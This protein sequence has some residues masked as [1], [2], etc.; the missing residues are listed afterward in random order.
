MVNL[1]RRAG[2]DLHFVR[3]ILWLKHRFI[4]NVPFKPYT[5]LL[6]LKPVA[7]AVGAYIIIKVQLISSY[8]AVGKVGIKVLHV[9]PVAC[10]KV[11]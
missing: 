7:L 10:L 11:V 1:R 3:K 5:Y 9:A 2:L 8:L 4:C 6:Y